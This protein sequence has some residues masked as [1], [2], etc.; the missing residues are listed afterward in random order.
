MLQDYRSTERHSGST[1]F[2]ESCT[3]CDSHA[4]FERV[5]SHMDLGLGDKQG[6]AHIVGVSHLFKKMLSVR[7]FVNHPE[8]K[9]KFESLVR[10]EPQIGCS[11]VDVC[12]AFR[13][14]DALKAPPG[15]REHMGL[16][17][18]RDHQAIGADQPRQTL[19]IEARPAS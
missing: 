13:E 16:Q 11:G 19:G 6:R 7:N 4:G 2:H 12:G 9:G 1:Y 10:A 5:S 3:P 15:H 17:I 8:S 18:N 14:P